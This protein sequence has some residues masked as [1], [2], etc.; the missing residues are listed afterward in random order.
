[1]GSTS[2]ADVL[3]I[4]AGVVGLSVARA[5]AMRG[6]EVVVAERHRRVGEETSS[7]NSGVIHSG[8]YYPTGSAKARLC[9]RG[10]EMLYAYC[11]EKGVA[12]RRIGKLIVAQESEI[13]KLRQLQQQAV[14]NAVTDLA[15]LEASEARQLE[16]QVRCAAALL[17]PSTGIID[18][19]E[20]MTA[21]HGDLEHYGGTVAF[22]AELLNADAGAGRMHVELRSGAARVRVECALLVNAAGLHAV[23]LLRKIPSFPAARIPEHYLAKGNYFDCRGPVPF[24]R[25]VYPL[26]AQ[27]GLGIHATLDLAGRLRFG[28]DVEWLERIDYR[29]DAGRAGE[30]YNAIRQY[31]PSLPDDAL[32]PSYAGIRPKL[33]PRGAAAQDFRIELPREHGVTG[34]V[35]LLGIE[36]PG[37]TAALAIGAHIVEHLAC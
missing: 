26:P 17:C 21:L 28:P 7:R 24:R 4:G 25:L 18:V 10:R 6:L 9:V 11:A 31:W 15:W 5:L 1:M 13:Q 35:N 16:P 14:A 30:F 29:V 36:S 22:D 2:S 23:D 37:L 19:H 8:I 33:V 20:L 34:L 3:V 12:H 27:A 32:T